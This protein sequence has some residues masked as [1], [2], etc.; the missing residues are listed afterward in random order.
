MGQ[1]FSAARLV[2]KTR[3][4]VDHDLLNLTDTGSHDAL[5]HC[6]RLIKLEGREI[7]L[8]A[9]GVRHDYGIHSRH[10]ARRLIVRHGTR[11]GYVALLNPP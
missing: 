2:E 9:S 4:A 3:H 5:R 10:E 11:A 8:P 1:V 6:H 7:L